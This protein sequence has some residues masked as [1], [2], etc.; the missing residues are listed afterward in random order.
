MIR[1]ANRPRLKSLSLT[2]IYQTLTGD[3]PIPRLASAKQQ[4]LFRREYRAWAAVARAEQSSSI[5]HPIDELLGEHHFLRM[6][7]EAMQTEAAKVATKRGMNFDFWANA[8][9]VV[10]NFGLLLHW[11][12]KA[13]HLFPI[14]RDRGF[15][16]DL[17]TLDE[18]QQRDIETTLEVCNAVQEGDAEKV[19]RLVSL[20]I[21]SKR[22]HMTREEDTVLLP[23]KD[24]LD[25]ADTDLLR[26]SFD[27]VD[28]SAMPG[29]DRKHYL[30]VAEA[31]WK[32]VGF[33]PTA[34]IV[35]LD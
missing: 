19:V 13:S 5:Q 10:G 2:A 33:D 17:D 25:V 18:E 30:S 31:V 15:D 16:G 22:R 29:A 4:N 32:H 3:L 8:V 1:V 28:A 11:R 35:A 24:A 26:K 12:K 6:V 9:D 27:E 21:D 34:P 7:F 14:L 23:A 20:F